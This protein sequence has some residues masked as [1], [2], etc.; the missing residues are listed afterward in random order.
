MI[1]MNDS[2]KSVYIA[3]LN[4]AHAMEEG[5]IKVL[6]SQIEAT[7]GKPEMRAKLEEHLVETKR[8]AELV[9]GCIERHGESPSGGKDLL[10]KMSAAI[11]SAG[12][13]L[14]SDA[15][16]K[17][18]HSSYAAEHFEI[19]SYTVI[20]AAALELGDTETATVCEEILT[21][22]E[23]MAAWLRESIPLVVAEHLAAEVA[24]SA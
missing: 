4:D 20:R 8:H 13:S 24:E 16:V 5:L 15:L 6:E 2:Q 3:W 22:E 17:N 7:E 18:V 14:A 10:S 23:D 12:M 19:A 1:P 21:D 11:N 9:R